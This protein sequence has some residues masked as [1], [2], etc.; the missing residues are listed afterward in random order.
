MRVKLPT[1]HLLEVLSPKGGC[2]G[3]SKS[4]LA[5]MSNC[6]KSHATTQMSS[7]PILFVKGRAPDEIYLASK[8][9]MIKVG[10]A[11]VIGYGRDQNLH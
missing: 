6:W 5:K 1:E 2:A 11:M 3:S 9:A 4:T 8:K 7:F 10:E